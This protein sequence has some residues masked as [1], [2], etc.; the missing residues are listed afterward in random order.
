M[1]ERKLNVSAKW[2]LHPTVAGG[3]LYCKLCCVVPCFVTPDRMTRSE[4]VHKNKSFSKTNSSF[5]DGSFGFVVFALYIVSTLIE[6]NLNEIVNYVGTANSTDSTLYA[7]FSQSQTE[8]CH[9]FDLLSEDLMCL[10]LVLIM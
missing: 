9:C 10:S 3:V 1:G 7:L 5:D 4:I 6:L 8:Y 2:L